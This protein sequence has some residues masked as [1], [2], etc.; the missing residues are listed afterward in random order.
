M[1]RP[2]KPEV[3]IAREISVREGKPRPFGV[4]WVVGA[5]EPDRWFAQRAEA[6]SFRARLIVA[7]ENRERFSRVTGLP[8]SWAETDESV[9]DFAKKWYL[10]KKNVW[11]PNSRR[12][13]A[14][15]L[16]RLLVVLVRGGTAKL[17]NSE[18]NA[19]AREVTAWLVD[20]TGERP[21]PRH[22]KKSMKLADLTANVGVDADVAVSS[23]WE[24]GA[25]PGSLLA[26]RTQSRHRRVIRAMFD[27][28]VTRRLIDEQPWPGSKSLVRGRKNTKKT[29]DR[30]RLP[31]RDQALATI[32]AVGISKKASRSYRMVLH[33][34]LYAGL[35]PAEAIALRVEDLTFPGEGQTNGSIRVDVAM[36]SAGELFT[37][38]GEEVG[39]PKTAPRDV[40][41]FPPLVDLLREWVGDR[42]EGHLFVDHQGK[43]PLRDS[44]DHGWQRAKKA[45][46]PGC[47]WSLY[48]LRHLCATLWVDA[49]V[50]L[51]VAARWLGHT[52]PTLLE[53]YVGSVE[54]SEEVGLARASSVFD[55]V[56]TPPVAD[57]KPSRPR[58]KG[59]G[60][61]PS[62]K[63]T[64]AKGD[65]RKTPSTYRRKNAGESKRTGSR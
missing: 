18:R 25:A 8:E 2:R 24:A 41:M 62:R 48:S 34:M 32:G 63:A 65:A 10:I 44:I 33:T 20:G 37:E 4:R 15:S 5:K 61:A 22:L 57:T 46:H 55:V 38:P 45:T 28:A 17:T 30:S 64:G 56:P 42:T 43:L 52:V 12:S 59:V 3:R 51:A 54:G 53:F 50:P 36:T 23:R 14:E 21:A 13:S 60:A 16:A 27:D 19:I 39:D 35:R 49:G 6:D 40:P 31:S 26:A 7:V 11:K 58:S 47:E 29:V 1:G 9:A